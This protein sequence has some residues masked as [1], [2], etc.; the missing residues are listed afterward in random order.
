M[1]TLWTSSLEPADARDYDAFVDAAASAHHTQKAAYATVAL[2]T[3]R[4]TASYFLARSGGKVVGAGLILRPRAWGRVVAPV[5]ILERGPV[6][7]STETL[8]PVLEALVREARKHAVARLS[9]MPYWSGDDVAGAE[10]ALAAA[11]FRDVQEFDSAHACTLRLD[12][13]GKTDDAILAGNERKKLRYE[14]R[15]AERAGA[16]VRRWN[17]RDRADIDTLARLDAELAVS[18]GKSPR[19]TPWFE[20]LASYLAG[21]ETR[22]ALFLCEHEGQ[23][24]SAAVVLRQGRVAV[25]QAGA[26]ILAHRPF[27]KMALPLF[28]AATWARDAGVA[29]FDL[30][31]VA[32]PGDEDPK[33]AAIAQFKRDFSKTAVY[34]VREHARWF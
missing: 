19:A 23:P 9:V 1:E 6:A 32:L 16:T 21:D 15:L 17:G 34:L 11:G 25:Y 22:G 29:T 10:T 4:R 12:V 27:S 2:A 13:S 24:V 14:L 26:S 7:A 5:A 8:Q 18:Q 31:G 20:A 33:R 3:R 28:A 30:G